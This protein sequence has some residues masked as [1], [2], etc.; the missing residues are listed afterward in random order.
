MTQGLSANELAQIRADV[1]GLLPDTCDILEVTRTSDGAGSWVETWGTATADV[2]CRLDFRSYG[3]EA[4]NATVL[5]P[6]KGEII[7]ME[8]DETIT[9]ANRV[10]L[11][12]VTYNITGV[13]DNQSWIGVKRVSVE[14]V[15]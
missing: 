8:Y 2:R 10:L 7:S 13:N 11:N 3:K 4:M 1:A 9:T 14:R 6:F 12:S 5:T 15:P